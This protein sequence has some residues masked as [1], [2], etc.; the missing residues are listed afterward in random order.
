MP[1]RGKRAAKSSRRS[2]SSLLSRVPECDADPGV[3]LAHH[4]EIVEG[5]SDSEDKLHQHFEGSDAAKG[6]CTHD[7]KVTRVAN[8]RLPCL[9]CQ[10]FSLFAFQHNRIGTIL[11][12]RD[13]RLRIAVFCSL[14]LLVSLSKHF[15]SLVQLYRPSHEHSHLLPAILPDSS[16]RRTEQRRKT[17]CVRN[18]AKIR[19]DA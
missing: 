7:D 19:V 11:L 1:R 4:R 18:V 8:R 9:T 3:R 13:A 5:C 16:E 6:K 15:R 17:R 12:G 14:P 10:A 2:Q